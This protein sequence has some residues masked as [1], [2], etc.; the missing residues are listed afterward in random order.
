MSQVCPRC[1]RSAP[2][3]AIY[4]PYCSRALK[5]A[6][7]TGRVSAAGVLM[8]VATVGFLVVFIISLNALLQ[9]YS[10]Y[11]LLTAQK[12][13]FFDEILTS[14]CFCGLLF[15]AATSTLVFIRRRHRLAL[16]LGILCLISGSGVWITSLV[17]PEL[18]LYYSVLYYFLHDL[19]APLIAI[20]VIYRRKP[21]FR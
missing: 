18:K 6:A 17:I 20:L 21:E 15:G 3:D 1:G 5:P 13:F 19:I 14:F 11:P 7:Q 9:I 2:P 8:L 4:C 10:W 16:A 12:W